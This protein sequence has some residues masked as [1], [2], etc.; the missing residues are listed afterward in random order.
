MSIDNDND[1]D[2]D[3][4]TATAIKIPYAP[5]MEDRIVEMAS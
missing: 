5:A 4:L 3:C 1:G 2:I